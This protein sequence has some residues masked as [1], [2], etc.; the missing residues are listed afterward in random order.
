MSK[1]IKLS[2]SVQNALDRFEEAVVLNARSFEISPGVQEMR[3]QEL[4]KARNE[5]HRLLLQQQSRLKAA[6]KAQSRRIY[7]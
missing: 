5:L 7:D 1:T 6:S 4:I 2:P 3:E